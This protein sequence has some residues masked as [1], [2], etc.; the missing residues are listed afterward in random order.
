MPWAVCCGPTAARSADWFARASGV[1]ATKADGPS[2]RGGRR[3]SGCGRAARARPGLSRPA[4]RTR[5]AA[6]GAKPWADSPLG[7]RANPGQIESE[8]GEL[9]QTGST[10]R[11]LVRW[12]AASS[13]E[14][15]RSRHPRVSRGHHQS[16]RRACGDTHRYRCGTATSVWLHGAGTHH[17]PRDAGRM[18]GDMAPPRS[19]CPRALRA[20][21]W[22]TVTRRAAGGGDAPLA[23]H[24]AS[25]TITP[26]Q[27][28]LAA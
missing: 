16:P 19:L 20:G 4:R 9:S 1:S 8:H 3:C 25:G 26:V 7:G 6:A 22:L 5:Q 14:P 24:P 11:S 23:A 18:A 17:A 28:C 21:A 15:G 12:F 10:A 13:G 27:T 2:R